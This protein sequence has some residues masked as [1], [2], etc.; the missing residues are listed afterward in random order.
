VKRIV[1][2]AIAVMIIFA[3]CGD[4]NSNESGSAQSTVSQQTN[5]SQKQNTTISKEAGNSDQQ[6]TTGST[7]KNGNNIDDVQSQ[8]DELESMLKDLD[9]VS[10]SDL[11]IPNP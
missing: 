3:G 6:K 7:L 2:V 10:N 9:D 1:F 4:L 5:S 8:L 11:E